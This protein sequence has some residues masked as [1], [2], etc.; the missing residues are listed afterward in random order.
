MN[1]QNTFNQSDIIETPRAASGQ[2]LNAI[3]LNDLAVNE[4]LAAE[5]KGGV[6]T[7]EYLLLGAALTPRP[8][9]QT[10]RP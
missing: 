6:V 10:S 4:T 7:I 2:A 9:A 8:T 1:Q 3:P 5:V